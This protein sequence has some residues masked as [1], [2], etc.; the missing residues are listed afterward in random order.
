[1]L[2]GRDFGA[3]KATSCIKVQMFM[4]V[5]NVHSFRP[6]RK[7]MVMEAGTGMLPNEVWDGWPTSDAM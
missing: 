6:V 1:M 4:S 3:N 2:T 5:S 7:V